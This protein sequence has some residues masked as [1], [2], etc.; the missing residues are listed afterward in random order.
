M[1]Y[2]WLSFIKSINPWCIKTLKCMVWYADLGKT[3][4]T[5]QLASWLHNL[6][7]AGPAQGLITYCYHLGN[8]WTIFKGD[9]RLCSLSREHIQSILQ[10]CTIV[11]FEKLRPMWSCCVKHL[12]KGFIYLLER[13]VF[14]PM[15]HCPHH[16]NSWGC[17][18]LKPGVRSILRDLQMGGDG[19]RGPR[20]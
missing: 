3:S 17:A 7:I 6:L 2:I 11:F 9:M 20:T 1:K 12:L 14:H 10:K 18:D 4:G 15:V 8:S 19:C 13:A 5:L 16:H